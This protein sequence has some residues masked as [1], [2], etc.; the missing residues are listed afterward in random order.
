M[1]VSLCLPD[2][3]SAANLIRESKEEF[4]RILFLT[5]KKAQMAIRCISSPLR[6]GRGFHLCSRPFHLGAWVPGLFRVCLC[7]SLIC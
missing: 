7:I 3:E 2:E 6:R 1:N 4:Q 5:P